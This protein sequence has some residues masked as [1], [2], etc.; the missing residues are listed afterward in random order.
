MKPQL[1]QIRRKAFTLIE[2]LVV[3][4]IISILAA[5]LFPV[6]ARAR[7][8]ARRASCVSNLKQI[9]L[10]WLMYAQ[11]NDGK[12]P[13]FDYT[14]SQMGKVAPYVKSDQIFICPSANLP[15]TSQYPLS[16][17]PTY[18]YGT[19]Y[20]MPTIY[21]NAGKAALQ[22]TG[23]ANNLGPV[24]LMDSVPSP[25]ATCLVA[26]TFRATGSFA[27][28]AG[29][30]TFRANP[31]APLDITTDTNFGGLA[32]V[33]RHFDGSNYAFMDG[34]VKWLKKEAVLVPHAQNQT[35]QF[36]WN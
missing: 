16:T 33:T 24:T 9:A 27:N 30:D 31:I 36:Y 32:D 19:D 14:Y 1:L 7:E 4:V 10:G 34:H 21:T 35:I 22:S 28:K 11:D 5:I 26:E 25:A 15:L 3:I 2:L 20:G 23:S 18:A 29:W 6:F 8:N 13:C 17:Y 12:L